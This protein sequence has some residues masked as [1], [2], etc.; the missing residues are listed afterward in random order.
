MIGKD[1]E[2]YNCGSTQWLETHHIFGGANRQKSDNYGLTVK[3]CHYCHNEPPN[4]VH[5]NREAMERLH[6]VGQ[7]HAMTVLGW[8][9]D[10][11]R[12]EIGRNYLDES[13]IEYIEKELL[14]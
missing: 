4:G 5:H 9:I 1:N 8:D 10:R 12:K 13:E 7:I 6:K 11:F 2:C 14:K 3:L